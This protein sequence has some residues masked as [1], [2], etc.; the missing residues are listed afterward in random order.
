MDDSTQIIFFLL[1]KIDQFALIRSGHT[2][3]SLSM[4]N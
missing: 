4:E 2:F 3:R 1:F